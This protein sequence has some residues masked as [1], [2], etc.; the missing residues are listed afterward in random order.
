MK[1]EVTDAMVE[2]AMCTFYSIDRSTFTDTTTA[3]AQAIAAAIKASGLVEENERLRADVA[4]LDNL[5]EFWHG[6]VVLARKQ[7]EEASHRLD[8]W[9]K[10]R[11]IS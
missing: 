11:P 6:C 3:H 5:Q 2:A 7:L 10:E 4:R 1:Y 8:K 9:M